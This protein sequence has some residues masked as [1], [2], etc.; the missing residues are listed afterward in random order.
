MSKILIAD[1]SEFVRNM[2]K[3][4]LEKSGYTEIYFA[5]DGREA[6][7]K[8]REIQPDIVVMDTIMPNITGL[9][10]LKTIISEYPQAK[11]IV[12]SIMGQEADV[13]NAISL[14]AKDFIVKPFK[15]EK[16]LKIINNF[17]T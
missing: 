3:N 12:C 8:Y 10:A 11:I 7:E 6:I 5:C 14:G 17:D 4:T 16:I 13:V 1:D 9:D 15:P 2:M